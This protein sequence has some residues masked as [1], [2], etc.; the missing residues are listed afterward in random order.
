[1][2][3]NINPVRL[4]PTEQLLE[5]V[6]GAPP[7][8]FGRQWRHGDVDDGSG[9]FQLPEMALSFSYDGIFQLVN[10]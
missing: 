6:L 1:M 9:V 3:A 5:A 7:E 2:T 10:N 4:A 8:W